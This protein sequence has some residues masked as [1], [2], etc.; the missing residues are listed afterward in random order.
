MPNRGSPVSFL[1]LAEEPTARPFDTRGWRF[2][3]TAGATPLQRRKPSLGLQ[4][5][6]VFRQSNP[7]E[8]QGL[9]SSPPIPGQPHEAGGHG[10]R[11]SSCDKLLVGSVTSPDQTA[12]ARQKPRFVP[13]K[14]M[15]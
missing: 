13:D 7:L 9:K 11:K 5:E 14:R 1:L 10:T 2:R 4:L 15:A 8:T 12:N 6:S 3:P